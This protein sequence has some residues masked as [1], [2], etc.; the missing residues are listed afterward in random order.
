MR[1]GNLAKYNYNRVAMKIK[2]LFLSFLSIPFFLFPQSEKNISLKKI[3]EGDYAEKTLPPFQSD[4]EGENYTRLSN[5][6]SMIIAYS[7]KTG[8]P[9]D[10]LFNAKKARECNFDDI[11]GYKI[12]PNGHHILVWRETE[13]LYRNLFSAVYYD[14][15]VR[16]N[17]ISPLSDSGDRQMVPLFSPDGRMCAYV[18]DNNI[19]LR[20]FDFS[21]ESQVTKDGTADSLLNGIPDWLYDEEFGQNPLMAWS[22]DSKILSFVKLDIAQVGNFPLQDYGDGGYPVEINTKYP[23]AGTTNPKATVHAYI[24]ETKDIKDLKIPGNTD[25][26]IPRITFTLHSDQLAVMTFNRVQNTFQIY[27]LNPKSGVSRLILREESKTYLEPNIL[28]SIKFYDEGFTFMSD[29]DGYSHLYLYSPTGSLLRQMT[30]GNWDVTRCLG[31]NPISKNIYYESTEEGSIYRSVYR[32]DAKGNKTKLT[33]R[34]GTNT[35]EFSENFHY[36][37]NKYTNI[38]TPAVISVC[39]G[40]GKELRVIEDNENLKR[41]LDNMKIPEKEFLSVENSEGIRLNAWMLKPVDFST[42]KKYPVIVLQYSGPGSQLVRD[43]YDFGWEYYLASKGYIV[44]AVDPR[45]TGGRGAAFAK[46]QYLKLGI[47]ESDDLIDVARYLNTLS[48]VD[49]KRLAIWGWSYGG[50]TSIMTLSRSENLYKVGIAIAPVT[51]WKF[52]DTAYTERYML[53]PGENAQGYENTSLINL[54]GKLNGNLYLIHPTLDKNVHL[55]NSLLYVKA[56][57]ESNKFC[58]MML[59]TGKDHSIKGQQARWNL[60]QGIVRYLNT[61]L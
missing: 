22:P 52:Y 55:Q 32:S 46:S 20:K 28:E 10:T 54:S 27:Y 14:F 11:E 19:W 5:D 33:A 44:L 37:I 13:P 39:D 48:Y 43:R 16:R 17:Y 18:K 58:N 47:N 61:N 51:D 42:D 34:K 60:Y 56:L 31:Y 38:N 50:F 6:K 29:R 36:F 41:K 21:T 26:Y 1:N 53:T 8:N 7:Y 25:G 23:M 49:N 59:F 15:D 4:P 57:E 30:S 40:N 35:A 9:V 45:G 3:V 2:I 12:S 24:V